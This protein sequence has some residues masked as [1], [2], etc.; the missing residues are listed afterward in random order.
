MPELAS[1]S[2]RRDDSRQRAPE[3]TQ[4]PARRR[5]IARAVEPNNERI[6]FVLLTEGDKPVYLNLESS[7][8]YKRM[9]GP[10]AVLPPV[11]KPVPPGKERDAC[12]ENLRGGLRVPAAAAKPSPA[13]AVPGLAPEYLKPSQ[14]APEGPLDLQE[15]DLVDRQKTLA[16]VD[17]RFANQEQARQLGSAYVLNR[18][19]DAKLRGGVNEAQWTLGDMSDRF[20]S[21]QQREG[22]FPSLER[23][24]AL[25]L[26][27]EGASRVLPKEIQ[28]SYI[29]GIQKTLSAVPD[30]NVINAHQVVAKDRLSSALE[31][32]RIYGGAE[33][34]LGK[35]EVKSMDARGSSSQGRLVHQLQAVIEGTSPADRAESMGHILQAMEGARGRLMLAG[36]LRGNTAQAA[37]A[38]QA[39]QMRGPVSVPKGGLSLETQQ[40][41]LEKAEEARAPFVQKAVQED[42][43]K[44]GGYLGYRQQALG[45]AGAGRMDD[46]KVS[47]DLA[48]VHWEN[49]RGE[50]RPE[51]LA[52]LR[53][54]GFGPGQVLE[55]VKG[56]HP[57][58]QQE[59]WGQ[60]RLERIMAQIPAGAEGHQAFLY[61]QPGRQ[62]D[63]FMPLAAYRQGGTQYLAFEHKGRVVAEPLETLTQD[64]K[65]P[66]H[67]V[68]LGLTEV[69]G[70][71]GFEMSRHGFSEQYRMT[72][73]ASA[74]HGVRAA[75]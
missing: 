46:A 60:A 28:Q 33:A 61:R 38:D 2:P 43:D 22:R 65:R 3:R 13:Q 48:V 32:V 21:L 10:D 30:P 72:G 54:K 19:L 6:S 12:A 17:P 70:K 8:L 49:L 71:G 31:K 57:N 23:L 25:Q 55:E 73:A 39:A 64:P 20:V 47:L 24:E 68:A 44:V 67:A 56:V 59:A 7:A 41:L 27:P 1:N 18:V 45:H 40:R 4:D 62:M 58:V 37:I 69:A 66:G 50:V 26:A 34:A 29:D 36:K 9:N 51:T 16:S 14:A 74:F 15:R 75:S 5:E 53:E 35:V 42:F 11:T 52:A 63:E